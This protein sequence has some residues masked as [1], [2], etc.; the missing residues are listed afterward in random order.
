MDCIELLFH[1]G[2]WEIMEF[3]RIEI[4]EENMG[5]YMSIILNRI[6]SILPTYEQSIKDN[7]LHTIPSYLDKIVVEIEGFYINTK[8]MERLLSI[9]NILSTIRDDIQDGK[10][11]SSDDIK[12]YVFHCISIIKRLKVEH[13]IL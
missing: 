13:G 8:D 9:V 11:F 12:S 5:H 2:R 10:T 1:S 7:N 4:T 3:D 6:F